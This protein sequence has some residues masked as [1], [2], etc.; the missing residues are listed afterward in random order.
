MHREIL[1]VLPGV[2]VNHRDGDGLN[3]RR[4]NLRTATPTEN[5]R[6]RAVNREHTS[7]YKGVSWSAR[8]EQQYKAGG[9]WIVQ[10]HIGDRTFHR[11]AATEVEAALIYNRLA[12]EHFGEFARL[13]IIESEEIARV[14]A[15]IKAYKGPWK[16]RR[17]EQF[18]DLTQPALIR[19]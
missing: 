4:S 11:G 9:I 18:M 7:R 6:N 17:L 16:E 2:M 1:G 12:A 13:N 8:P 19:G 15:E 3:N 10:V 5:A 14:Q